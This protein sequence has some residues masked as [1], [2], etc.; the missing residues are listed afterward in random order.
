VGWGRRR[1]VGLEGAPHVVAH[2]V[3][4][5]VGKGDIIGAGG[6][7]RDDGFQIKTGKLI[8]VTKPPHEEL[9]DH[10][11]LHPFTVG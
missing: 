3:E 7:T 8:A 2:L 10:R 5:L 4:V 11:G 1:F 6:D 9:R